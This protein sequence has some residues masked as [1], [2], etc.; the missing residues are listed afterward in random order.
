MRQEQKLRI[1]IE[2]LDHGYQASVPSVNGLRSVGL[3]ERETLERLS[4]AA[5]AHFQVPSV[6][7][8]IF[9]T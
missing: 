6:R 7:L 1:E 3:T 8:E 5:A 2:R 4:A 9:R